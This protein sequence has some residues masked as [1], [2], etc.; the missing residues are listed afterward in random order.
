ML[1][2][3][4]VEPQDKMAVSEALRT[5]ARL[6]VLPMRF[7]GGFRDAGIPA[8]VI[9]PLQILG[10]FLLPARNAI[11]FVDRWCVSRGDAGGDRSKRFERGDWLD[12]GHGATGHRGPPPSPLHGGC[13]CPPIHSRGLVFPN[14]AYSIRRTKARQKGLLPSTTLRAPATTGRLYAVGGIDMDGY[15]LI[16]GYD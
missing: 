10:Y 8:A 7:P 14:F 3:V 2:A 16:L 5:V 4:G 6:S 11:G 12:R 15:L 1:C 9:S 13:K